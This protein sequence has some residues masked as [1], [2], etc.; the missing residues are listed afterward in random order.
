MRVD[1]YKVEQE[2]G[3]QAAGYKQLLPVLAGEWTL[4]DARRRA[5]DATRALAGR[6]RTYF[7][8]DPRLVRIEW[9]DDAEQRADRLLAVLEEA[10]WTS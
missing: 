2:G 5:I 3:P 9:H 6:Q 1:L 8:K 10:G 7:G 4:G